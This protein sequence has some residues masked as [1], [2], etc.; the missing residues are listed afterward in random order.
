M[1]TKR[2]LRVLSLSVIL[3]ILMVALPLLIG[4]GKGGFELTNIFNQFLLY[5]ITGGIFLIGVIIIWVYTSVKGDTKYGLGICY[6]EIGEFPSLSMFKNVSAFQMLLG[7]IIVIGFIGLYAFVNQQQ[8]F[9]GVGVVTSIS[10][11]YTNVDNLLFSTALI[12]AAENLSAAF[13]IAALLLY[14]RRL[15]KKFN[16]D[17]IAF[18][19]V[20]IMLIPFVI[21][22]T[23]IANHQLRYSGQDIAL[24]N[25]FFFWTVLGLVT[26]LTGSFIPGLIMHIFNNGFYDLLKETSTDLIYVY[27]GGALTILLVLYVWLYYIRKKRKVE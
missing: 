1:D 18:Q 13:V 22:L 10:Q 16:W 3:I 12:P 6:S 4:L 2:L 5:G 14:A 17:P 24:I 21:G 8:T 27:V 15:M 19:I 23:G 26:L 20:V 11:Q 25:V 9:T 7:S